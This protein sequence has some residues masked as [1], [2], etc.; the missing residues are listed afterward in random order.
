MEPTTTWP[1]S[2]RPGFI[3]ATLPQERRPVYSRK[4]GMRG[5]HCPSGPG[6]ASNGN[7]RFLDVFIELDA[8][9][10]V[11]TMRRREGG[12]NTGIS[13]RSA[14][15][16]LAVLTTSPRAVAKVALPTPGINMIHPTFVSVPA[17]L[18]STADIVSIRPSRFLNLI[19]TGTILKSRKVAC[20]KEQRGVW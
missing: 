7:E 11:K 19:D 4:R 13:I 15:F 18:G 20:F 16:K 10:F 12:G 2:F 6:F 8:R 17:G 3:L 1:I 14:T 9:T 5:R